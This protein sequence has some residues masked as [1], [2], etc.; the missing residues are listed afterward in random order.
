METKETMDDGR[1]TV[2][3]M[4]RRVGASMSNLVFS[5]VTR[6]STHHTLEQ[7]SRSTPPYHTLPLSHLYPMQPP[8]KRVLRP[9]ASQPTTAEHYGRQHGIPEHVQAALQNVGRKGR[10][11]GSV[12]P[13]RCF[14]SSFTLNQATLDMTDCR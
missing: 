4:S 6:L 1:W 12:G 10:M 3:A 7:L 9:T 14:C 5:I 11:G 8:S 13:C 2:D